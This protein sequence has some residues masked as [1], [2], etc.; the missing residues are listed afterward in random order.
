MKAMS[1]AG[2]KLTANGLTYNV[3]L[4]VRG[5]AKISHEKSNVQILFTETVEAKSADVVSTLEATL[6]N[7]ASECSLA[8]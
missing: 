6:A 8:I 4:H 5:Y 3:V 1:N 7:V 2:E